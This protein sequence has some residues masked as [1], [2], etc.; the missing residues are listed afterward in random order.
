MNYPTIVL[1]PKREASLKR[2]H[3]WVFS[4]AIAKIE[5]GPEQDLQA[6]NVVQV[7][8]LKGRFYG[9]GHFS[10]G[11]IAVRILSF[12]EAALKADFFLEKIQSAHKLRLELG[13]VDNKETQAY[14]LVHGEGDG[15]GGLII[16]IYYQV[17]VIQ[18]HSV[19]MLKSLDL[20]VNSLQKI[21]GKK[22]KAI[23]NKSEQSV[24]HPN[25]IVADGYLWGE[26]DTP[27]L[28]KENALNFEVDWVKGQKTGFFLDQR[29][30]RNL[31]AQY[32]KGKSVLNTFC[33]TGGFSVYALAAGAKEVHS[34]DSSEI[35]TQL[36]DKNVAFL[37]TAG[38]HQSFT[39]DTLDYLKQCQSQYD[40][41]V[42][43]PPA[44]A[45]HPRAKHK[46]VQAYRR[47]NQMAMRLIKPGGYLFTFSC[48]QAVDRK[49]FEDSLRAASIDAKRSV[50][51][52][53]H[54]SQPADH[55][56]SAFHPE[57]E[58]LKGLVLHLP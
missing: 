52:L 24:H 16:D 44:Y 57:G 39:E 10:E 22:L 27:F 9:C 54:L 18:A 6:G 58:Y 4:G 46:A 5:L 38:K 32:S 41:I 30:S 12:E 23:Y 40:V 29:E 42:L 45:K 28:L 14:R 43:D 3:P 15:L 7:R 55:P 26:A 48:S 47:L 53:H 36:T 49:L 34:V 2:R 35:A 56:V 25:E 31:L 20:I 51:I 33:Y 17:A 8:D 1:K 50:Q 19:G 21:Y 37:K 13:L 11:S